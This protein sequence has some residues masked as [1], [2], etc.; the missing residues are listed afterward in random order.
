MQ[1]PNRLIFRLH[2]VRRMF[3]REISEIGI[4]NVL[5]N[6]KVIQNYEDDIPYS[7][8]LVLGWID[9]RPIHVVIAINT[10]EQETIVITAYE[11]NLH[12]WK[13]GFQKRR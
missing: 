12:E 5:E 8:F 3:E 10:N 2:A 1:F 11:P 4:K 7:S 9:N 6:G 13:P